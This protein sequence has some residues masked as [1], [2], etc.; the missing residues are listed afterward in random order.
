MNNYK[1]NILD[2]CIRTI[3][4]VF[5]NNKNNLDEK[6]IIF[7]KYFDSNIN[8]ILDLFEKL[9][10]KYPCNKLLND[11]NLSNPMFII[12]ILLMINDLEINSIP[13]P[14]QIINEYVDGI[15]ILRKNYNYIVYPKIFDFNKKKFGTK[16]MIFLKS[17]NMESIE[18]KLYYFE[19]IKSE[20]PNNSSQIINNIQQNQK[21]TS[22]PLLSQKIIDG[23]SNIYLLIN[24][25]DF[26]NLQNFLFQLQ[27]EFVK[28]ENIILGRHPEYIHFN[29]FLNQNITNL[30][31]EINDY[32]LN[33]NNMRLK[34]KQLEDDIKILNNNYEFQYENKNYYSISY[35]INPKN[36]IGSNTNY[37]LV[38][39]FKYIQLLN[40]IRYLEYSVKNY[41]IE[42]SNSIYE[43]KYSNISSMYLEQ[44]NINYSNTLLKYK[45]I[46]YDL[47]LKI[48]Q[49]DSNLQIL[50]VSCL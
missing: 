32:E 11:N 30:E 12:H 17:I 23:Y 49:L 13:N 41:Q 47:E 46:I 35:Y 38:S 4:K 20:N 2:S 8:F 26:N 1:H 43:N 36:I 19:L 45:H 9:K 29:R 22:C 28:Y 40:K 42:E 18:Y 44:S 16:N 6:K 7:D 10:K 31:T 37:F 3:H 5:G 14:Y 15:K 33:I 48:K 21:L 24:K 39:K 34:I 25:E 50:V 27:N